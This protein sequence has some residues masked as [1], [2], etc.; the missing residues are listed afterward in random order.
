MLTK[1]L[2]E[3]SNEVFDQKPNTIYDLRQA[4]DPY[5][6]PND[7]LFVAV[8][9]DEVLSPLTATLAFSTHDV[10]VGEPVDCQLTI[11]SRARVGVPTIF[12]SEVRIIFDG[13][14][15]PI[16]LVDRDGD[17]A[18]VDT[19][20]PKTHFVDARMNEVSTALAPG[21]KRSSVSAITSQAG[22]ASLSIAPKNTKVIKLRVVPR[23]AGELSV[24]SITLMLCDAK[25][26]LTATNSSVSQTEIKWWEMKAGAPICR[27]LGQYSNANN[28]VNVQPKPPKLKLEVPV[29]RRSYY[30][31][32]PIII[33]FEVINE[34]ADDVVVILEARLISPVQGAAQVEWAGDG[35]GTSPATLAGTGILSL[36]SLELGIIASSDK[37]STSI[38]ITGT[39]VALDHEL[40]LLANYR[41]VPEPETHLVKNIT[42]DVGVIRP[43]EANYEFTPRLDA[44]PWP[45]FFEA[46]PSSADTTTPLGLRHLYSV[47]ASLYSYAT[48]VV[49]IEAILLTA[50]KVTGGAVCSSSTGIVRPKA[51]SGLATM[52]TAGVSKTDIISTVINPDNTEIFDFDLTLQ[53]LSLGNRQTVAVDLELE[54]AWRREDSDQ[55]NTTVL[56]AA[57]FVAPMAEPRVILTNSTTS[58]KVPHVNAHLLSFTI[59]NPS[60]HFLTFNVSM[61]ASEDFAFSGSKVCAISLVPIS[62]QTITYRVLPNKQDDWINVHL[63]VVDAYFGQTLKILPGGKD[64]KVD[65]KGNVLVKV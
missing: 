4:L 36:P 35:S 38:R 40:E 2:W 12:L 58:P 17:D 57:H 51:D 46:P 48:E 44:D 62:K 50:T 55:V 6:L 60:M 13:G 8:D 9:I 16:I 25:F 31:N 1:L 33:D 43:F 28:V 7:S 24:A 11:Q 23:E 65:K 47:A 63:N 20:A 56:E 37:T 64:V 21:S 41:L 49:V 27:T 45:N 3:L 42:I 22:T 52:G 34:E 18:E 15:K 54:I 10:F 59:E 26:T 53:K 19:A 39:T 32:E 5:G 61:D 14:L 29:L 30:T